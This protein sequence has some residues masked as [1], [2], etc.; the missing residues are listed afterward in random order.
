VAAAYVAPFVEALA[1]FEPAYPARNPIAKGAGLATSLQRPN[2]KS[3]QSCAFRA[4]GCWLLCF[5]SKIL[6]FYLPTVNKI[7]NKIMVASGK[8]SGKVGVDKGGL[9]SYG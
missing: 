8:I 4:F 1:G 3:Q 5:M 6:K 7:I 2:E 9:S